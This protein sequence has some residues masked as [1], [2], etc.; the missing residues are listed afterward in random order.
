MPNIR[1]RTGTEASDRAVLQARAVAL[2]FGIRTVDAPSKDDGGE[3]IPQVIGEIVQF[4]VEHA[5]LIGPIISAAFSGFLGYHE[6]R[7]ISV[8]ISFGEARLELD[9]PTSEIKP[10]VETF[11]AAHGAT[12]SEVEV[13]D[14]NNAPS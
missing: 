9:G 12:V 8:T 6:K 5:D 13:A 4:I 11:L 14:L 2:Q 10:I 7:R 3:R 1:I